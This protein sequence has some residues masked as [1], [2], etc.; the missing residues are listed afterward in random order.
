[1]NHQLYFVYREPQPRFRSMLVTAGLFLVAP[2][3]AAA[4]RIGAGDSHLSVD[5]FY[6]FQYKKIKAVPALAGMQIRI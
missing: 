6:A 3:K 2:S 5:P 1:M 4:L